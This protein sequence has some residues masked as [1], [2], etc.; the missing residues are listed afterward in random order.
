MRLV[1]VCL[2]HISPRAFG[3]QV[4]KD[5][6]ANQRVWD[7]LLGVVCPSVCLSVLVHGLVMC[8]SFC[9]CLKIWK[10]ILFHIR[11]VHCNKLSTLLQIKKSCFQL[12][13]TSAYTRDFPVRETVENSNI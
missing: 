4:V 2:W 1:N 8:C 5:L 3:G 10:F 9:L 12:T 6:T 13:L 7:S 11:R